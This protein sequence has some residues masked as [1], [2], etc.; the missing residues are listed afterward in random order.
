MICKAERTENPSIENA[1]W[2]KRPWN[3]FPVESIQHHMGNR[4]GHFPK[5]EVK[6][7]YDNTGVFVMFRVEDKY[8]RAVA[9]ADQDEV[10][11]DSCVEFF[12]CPGPDLS[13]GYFNLEMNCGG[14]MLFHFQ[15]RPR[16]D[17]TIIQE[18][19]CLRIDRLH[20]LPRIVEPE[21]K[22]PV[23]WTVAYRIPVALLEKYRKVV[24][25]APGAVWQV[26]FYKCA[27]NTSHPHW[28]TWAPVDSPKPDF[29]R[30]Q[31]FGLLKFQ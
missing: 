12:F 9:E 15:T 5:T 27:D 6:A 26:N 17:R 10:Y 31:Y 24:R 18:S 2:D 14:T 3:D 30:P 1:D 7:A 19:D 21:I 13:E 28:L 11:R 16:A 4:P 23:T 20:S 29:H 25:P 8:V 22:E